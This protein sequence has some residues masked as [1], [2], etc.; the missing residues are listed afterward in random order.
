MVLWG[1]VDHQIQAIQ[2]LFN[3]HLFNRTDT[4]SFTHEDIQRAHQFF[5]KHKMDYYGL[6]HSHPK[7]LPEPSMQDIKTG[8]KYHFI[9]GLRDQSSPIFNAFIIKGTQAVQIPF[10]VIDDSGFSSVDLHS[11]K[12]LDGTT[13]TQPGKGSQKGK[14]TL[15]G[16]GDSK[17]DY[18]PT[19]EEA[20][21]L[22]DRIHRIVHNKK[23]KYP[24]LDPQKPSDSDFSTLA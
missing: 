8:H 11:G 4:F 22:Q 15:K 19:Y 3:K 17:E 12:K 13:P 18:N 5:A 20:D 2:P 24:K 6:Y 1:G 16:K 10:D 14:K 21:A 7:G 9:L 23:N